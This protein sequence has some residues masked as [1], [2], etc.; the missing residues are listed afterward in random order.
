MAQSVYAESREADITCF[1]TLAIAALSCSIILSAGSVV[2]P[3]HAGSPTD[4]EITQELALLCLTSDDPP[5]DLCDALIVVGG[6]GGAPTVSSTSFNTG[7]LG[8]QGSSANLTAHQQRELLDKR[9]DGLKES[10]NNQDSGGGASAEITSGRLGLFSNLQYSNTERETTALGI[11]YDAAVPSIHVGA[12]Y[13]FTDRFVAGIVGGYSSSDTDFDGNAGRL[14]TDSYSGTLYG[15]LTP[16]R[17]IYADLYLGYASLNY[18][19][20]RTVSVGSSTGIA[21]GETD[22]NQWLAGASVEYQWAYDALTIVPYA[23]VD[24]AATDIDGYTEADKGGLGVAMS[25]EEQ[26]VRSLTTNFGVR[27]SYAFSTPVGVI[28]PQLRLAYVHEYKDD[29][30]QIDS[31]L[32]ISPTSGFSTPTD[33]PDRNYLLGGIGASIV[34]TGGVQLFTDY[35]LV[36]GHDLI[37]AWTL[38]AGIRVEM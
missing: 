25:Y 20:K 14:E 36:S 8:A 12:D 24:Y 21:K 9:L 11:G 23:K 35:E 18:D 22:G 15:S 33:N 2:S 1:G 26:E 28:V 37:D 10:G 13:R 3:A 29:A 5:A 16:T 27:G 7:I 19:S 32:V 30:R 31:A 4:D 34:L 6:S 38:S 17:N